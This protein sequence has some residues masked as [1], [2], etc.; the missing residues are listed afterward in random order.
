MRVWENVGFAFEVRGMNRRKRRIRVEELL[1]LVALPGVGDKF[2]HELSGGQRQRVAIARALAVAPQ[3]LLL[4]EPL[5]ALDLKLRQRMATELRLIQQRTEVTF[6]YITHDQSEAL[7][8]SDQVAV[9]SDGR[10]QQVGTPQTIYHRPDTAFVA[11]FVGENNQLP[12]TITSKS[13]GHALLA[14]SAGELSGVLN[15]S[16]LVPGDDAC[17]FIRP[18]RCHLADEAGPLTHNQIRARVVQLDFDGPS[19]ICSLQVDEQN[20]GGTARD[21]TI[22]LKVIYPH[23]LHQYSVGEPVRISFRPEDALVMVPGESTDE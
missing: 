3:V 20:S 8:M 23:G 22:I 14:T 5:S 21:S 17:L 7:A 16:E 6:I 11:T 10:I 19:Q 4:D 1:Q 9:M 12:G 15:T 13:S 18:E 2:P